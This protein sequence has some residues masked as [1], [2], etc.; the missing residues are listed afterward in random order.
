MVA[1]PTITNAVTGWAA[2]GAVGALAGWTTTRNVGSAAQIFGLAIV[3]IVGTVFGRYIAIDL[4]IYRLV[5]VQHGRWNWSVVPRD[6]A[7]PL[8][9]E[10]VQRLRLVT[11]AAA[12]VLRLG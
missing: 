3:G 5:P 9:V 10:C 4:P 7:L 12:G 11:G 2:I 8:R 1:Q 6:S